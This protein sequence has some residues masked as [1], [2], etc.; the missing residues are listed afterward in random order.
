MAQT[1]REQDSVDEQKLPRAVLY[2]ISGIVIATI[3]G[4]YI[5]GA[6][7]I[8]KNYSAL[9]LEKNAKNTIQLLIL[10]TLALLVLILLGESIIT[11]NL[12]VLF[13]L[14]VIPI[15]L[16]AKTYQGNA[17]KRH[18]LQGGYFHSNWIAFCIGI[19]TYFIVTAIGGV[20]FILLASA[21]R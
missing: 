7:L 10:I 4:T 5:A 11:N 16:L 19:A 18:I 20:F 2:K 14:Q 9:G 8:A 21:V 13:L 6:Y 3:F 17:I 1:A 12:F 15:Y